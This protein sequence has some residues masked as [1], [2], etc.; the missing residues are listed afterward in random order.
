M[1]S[2]EQRI[3]P[4]ENTYDAADVR[5]FIVAALATDPAVETRPRTTTR[6]HRGRALP[7]LSHH[8]NA[9]GVHRGHCRIRY[10]PRLDGHFPA[11][12]RGRPRG[13]ARRDRGSRPMTPAAARPDARRGDA[14]PVGQLAADLRDRGLDLTELHARIN[15][16][17]ETEEALPPTDEHLKQ[18]ESLRTSVTEL[19]DALTQARNRAVAR[20]VAA[21]WTYQRI[22][23]ATGLS[24]S[25]IGQIAPRRPRA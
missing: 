15:A 10:P 21:R 16:A 1:V 7:P 18:I 24:T 13:P 25:R 22:K 4:R 23:N 19:Q 11:A 5:A 8:R 20:A 3:S 9:Q 17:S 14:H 6:A 2:T 12:H